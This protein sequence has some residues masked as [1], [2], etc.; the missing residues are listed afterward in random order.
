MN[1]ETPIKILLIGDYLIFRIGLKMLIEAEERFNVVGEAAKI[2]EAPDLIVRNKPDVVLINAPEIKNG[3]FPE[4]MGKHRDVI[5]V[6]IL[7]NSDGKNIFKDC[8]ELGASGLVS[9]EKNP[10]IL[11]RAIEQ[12]YQGQLWFDRTLMGETIKQL[13]D[14][15]HNGN[16]KTDSDTHSLTERE[17]EVLTQVCKGLKNKNIA[18]NLFISETTVRHHLTSIFE[19]LNVDSRLQLVVLAFRKK[20]VEIPP[21]TVEMTQG[22]DYL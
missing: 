9:K 16:G 15:K 13:M 4:F 21:K 6:L 22:A 20:M 3:D 7:S 12:V 19:K 2:S 5:P 14:E 10:E 11:F 1:S 17:W 18:D 8:F